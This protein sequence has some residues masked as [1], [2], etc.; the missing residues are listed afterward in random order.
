MA[1]DAT[2]EYGVSTKIEKIRLVNINDILD[3]YKIKVVDLLKLNIEGGEY[4]LLEYLIETD[5]IKKFKNI[6]VQF[7]RSV[8]AFE[9][10]ANRIQQ[11]LRGTHKLTYQYPFVWENWSL[12]Q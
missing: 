7:H 6:Q 8:N 2:S 1:K 10:R 11:A 9:A 3:K 12:K 4:D 5:M